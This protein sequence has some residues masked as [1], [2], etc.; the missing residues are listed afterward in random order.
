VRPPKA[1]RPMA[2]SSHPWSSDRWTTRSRSV[3]RW[4]CRPG[5]PRRRREP[6]R[7]GPTLTACRWPRSCRR[8]SATRPGHPSQAPS[9]HH[10][11]SR[12]TEGAGAGAEGAAAAARR[13]VRHFPS[14]GQPVPVPSRPPAKSRWP[15]RRKS[16]EVE[17]A[18]AEVAAEEPRRSEW[19]RE[20]GP[21]P[22]WSFRTPEVREVQGVPTLP[23][24]PVA[25]SSSWPS[26]SAASAE[27]GA[28]EPRRSGWW[29]ESGPPPV[30]SFRTPEVREVRPPS[31]EEPEAPEGATG[32]TGVAEAVG[33][34]RSGWWRERPAS[35]TAGPA[36][37]AGP[38]PAE[39]AVRRPKAALGGAEP[40]VRPRK[41]E[42]EEEEEAAAEQ[43]PREPVPAERELAGAEP[44]RPGKR[45]LRSGWPGRSPWPRGWGPCRWA[46][47]G[48]ERGTRGDDRRRRRPGP[49]P[50]S[51]RAG[52]P[53][54]GTGARRRWSTGRCGARPP[55]GRSRSC[56]GHRA[57]GTG[58]SRRPGRRACFRTRRH[59][60]GGGLRRRS[61]ASLS[62]LPF[63][64]GSHRP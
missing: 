48:W 23:E 6:P 13:W 43:R 11:R 54:S 22:V 35:P 40:K 37:P 56:P 16:V 32:A 57:R 3:P 4:L 58:R 33:P 31:S 27:V 19:W 8:L 39:E 14:A 24:T 21:P 63:L 15:G 44:P 7:S 53:R 45:S 61:L 47:R 20:S 34:R 46:G 9:R 49:W 5:V 64:C 51:R 41:K 50:G 29:R 59:H 2:S 42:E 36:G 60:L 25:P 12:W 28:E 10:R 62:H 18:E 30:W 1:S 52:W 26:E 38:A 55:R 17:G